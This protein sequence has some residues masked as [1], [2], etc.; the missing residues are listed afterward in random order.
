MINKQK[1]IIL[2]LLML[3][4]GLIIYYLYM[5]PET[6]LFYN[7]P[8]TTLPI[9]PGCPTL[10]QPTIN[11]QSILSRFFGIGFNIIPVPNQTDKYLIEHIPVI[12]NGTAGSMYSISPDNQLTIKLR[13]EMDTSQW[14]SATS[15]TDDKGNYIVIQPFNIINRNNPT[16]LQYE[17]GNLALRPYNSN[18]VFE[19]QKWIFSQDKI[20]R[21]IPVLN[22]NPASL[23]T[24][25]FD[26]YSTSTNMNTSNIGQQNTQQV[27]DV[28]NVIKTNIQQYLQTIGASG[29]NV[30]QTSAST[31][32]LK[33]TPLNINLNLSGSM[34]GSSISGFSNI[35]GTTSPDDVLTLLDRYNNTPSNNN[36]LVSGNDLQ[37]S[38]TNS[39]GCSNINISDYTS[40]RVGSC[41]CNLST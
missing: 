40:S 23:F 4:T 16:A 32:G 19:S 13:N 26:P 20:T 5:K 25:E 11:N 1:L 34:T 7:E 31:L 14:W 35:D 12:Y 41:N 15:K 9:P 24:P 27:N 3:V 8:N 30:P 38:M 39:R 6:E 10:S 21:G 33:E 22:Y 28:I 17:N 36:L 29:S 2:V 18:N 37:T